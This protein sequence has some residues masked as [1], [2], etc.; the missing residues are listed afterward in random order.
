MFP[1]LR[2]V[3][4]GFANAKEKAGPRGPA[5]EPRPDLFS[6]ISAIPAAAGQLRNLGNYGQ[7]TMTA[8]KPYELINGG[9][10]AAMPAEFRESKKSRRLPSGSQ[11]AGRCL[12]ASGS[13]CQP[14][15]SGRM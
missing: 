14:R 13:A 9:D 4:S 11:T 12:S 2:I 8:G 7:H 15:L 6:L 10:D 3:C 5:V 1:D